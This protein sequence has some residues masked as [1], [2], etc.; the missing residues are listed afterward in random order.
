MWSTLVS[1]FLSAL[2]PGSQNLSVFPSAYHAIGVVFVLGTV[3]VV[4]IIV[5]VFIFCGPHVIF[6]A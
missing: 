4:L 5:I 6:I 2:P 1:V 3:R